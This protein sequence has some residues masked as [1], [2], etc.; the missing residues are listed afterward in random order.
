MSKTTP[1]RGEIRWIQFDQATRG[2]EQ[3][4]HRPG[5]VI[6]SSR[7]NESPA[8][9]VVALP[10]TTTDRSIPWH[11]Q[12]TP[13]EGN[14]S[15]TGYVMCDQPHTLAR[16]RFDDRIGSVTRSTMRNIEQRLLD[17]LEL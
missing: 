5:L 11:V 15:R 1:N 12:V 14:L 13:P 3:A 17:L 16:E 10:M 6:S 7:F 9:L 4:G 2:H 8:G